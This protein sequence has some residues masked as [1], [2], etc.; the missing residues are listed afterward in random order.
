MK[1]KEEAVIN[2]KKFTAI[3]PF[4]FTEPL[5]VYHLAGAQEANR[6]GDLRRVF[7]DAK[8]IVVG[9]SGFGFGRQIFKQIRDRVALALEAARAL[10]D[11]A[12]RLRPHA[13][14]VVDIIRAKTAFLNFFH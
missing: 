10:R 11:A 3:Y 13:D 6:I 14:R 12:R 9:R 1:I 2:K 7:H 8:N 5:E 4:C